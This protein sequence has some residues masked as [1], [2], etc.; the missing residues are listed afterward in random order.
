MVRS[1]L[2]GQ[3]NVFETEVRLHVALKESARAGRSILDFD[4]A[5]PSAA[6]Y[7]RLAREVLAVC[8]DEASPLPIGERPVD[9]LHALLD[10]PVM[11]APEGEIDGEAVPARRPRAQAPAFDSFLVE[12]WQRWLG[13]SS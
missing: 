4:G 8:G 3:V 12:G 1:S 2:A 9:E 5:S 10:L 11:A 6:S 13:A 7:R